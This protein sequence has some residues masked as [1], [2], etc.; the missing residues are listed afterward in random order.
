MGRS[1]RLLRSSYFSLLG[2]VFGVYAIQNLLYGTKWHA[3]HSESLKHGTTKATETSAFEMF[4]W[5][6]AQ[7]KYRL[8]IHRPTRDTHVEICQDKLQT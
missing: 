1:N 8:D 5:D 3:N 7:T 4:E 2:F 6:W